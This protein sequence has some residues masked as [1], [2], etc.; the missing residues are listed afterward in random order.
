[1]ERAIE[2]WSDTSD[3]IVEC[4]EAL[5]QSKQA[6]GM[7]SSS[8]STGRCYSACLR[9]NSVRLAPAHLVHPMFRCANTLPVCRYSL[10]DDERDI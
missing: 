7:F 5:E 2:R 3:E 4:H 6:I 10:D 9:M 1:M 8:V